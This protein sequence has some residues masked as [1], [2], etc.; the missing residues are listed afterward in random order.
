SDPATSPSRQPKAA[1]NS[2]VGGLVMGVALDWFAGLFAVCCRMSYWQIYPFRSDDDHASAS[3][4][5]QRNAG[6]RAKSPSV[7]HSVS[8]CS[9]ASAAKCASGTRLACTPDNASSSFNRLAWRSVVCG[10]QTVSHASQA[11]NACHVAFRRCLDLPAERPR[12]D[13]L[14]RIIKIFPSF[15]QRLQALF[16]AQTT[17]VQRSMTG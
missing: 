13:D 17:D 10:I 3:G 14:E 7:E 2:A 9:N 16:L 11:R 15:K 6:N 8:P 5:R 4:F 1:R 12:S